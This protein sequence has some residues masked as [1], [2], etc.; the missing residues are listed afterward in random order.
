MSEPEKLPPKITKLLTDVN[1]IIFAS[2]VSLWELQIKKSL[3]KIILPDAFALQ[4]Q[5][6]GYELL[7]VTPE[8][9]LKLENIPLLH[10]YPFDRML[11]AQS[12]FEKMPLVTKDSEILRYDLEFIK[13]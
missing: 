8:H 1:N 9:I 2:V 11:I 7:N 10:R 13:F 4:L 3:G 12:L 5:E 6:C